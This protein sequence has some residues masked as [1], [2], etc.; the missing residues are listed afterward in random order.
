M[1]PPMG[2]M[3]NKTDAT[4]HDPRVVANAII[5]CAQRME[6]PI[7]NISVQKLLYFAHAAFL[8]HHRRPL[9]RGVFEAWEFGPVCRSIYDA[10]KHYG[11]NEITSPIQRTDP[12][13][14][15][16][17]A[18]PEL[19]DPLA[20]R[21]IEHLMHVMGH[22]SP[23]QLISL[24]HVPG[25]AWSIVWNKAKTGATVGNRID[26]DLTIKTFGRLKVALQ[27]SQENEVLDE[28]SPFAG[29]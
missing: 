21:H 26:D 24:S 6:V 25:G 1:R 28:A 4:G 18:L 29:D 13:T 22:A 11:R 12:F 20:I 3:P 14:G 9:V 8:V 2:A 16:S 15:I 7:R 27:P 5:A 19:A 17:S 10:L 23:S